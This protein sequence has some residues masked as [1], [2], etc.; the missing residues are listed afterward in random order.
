MR[1]GI[2]AEG[3]AAGTGQRRGHV[4]RYLT[5]KCQANLTKT[6]LSHSIPT[7]G[8]CALAVEI[9]W[10]ALL[11]AT[12]TNYPATASTCSTI[13]LDSGAGERYPACMMSQTNTRKRVADRDSGSCVECGHED[14]RVHFL[15][16]DG[17]LY[18]DDCAE[19]IGLT[20]EN[21]DGTQ[22]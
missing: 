18:C 15:V 6:L 12:L 14:Y 13:L 5:G 9:L 16:H 4:K 7:V 22:S 20:E 17:K 21:Q 2:G 19:E 10:I 3:P 1:L 11:R 8:S